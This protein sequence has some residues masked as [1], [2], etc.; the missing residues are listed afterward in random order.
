MVERSRES[1]SGRPPTRSER[2]AATRGRLISAALEIVRERGPGALTTTELTRA[3][4]IAQPSFYV[5]FDNVDDCLSA[6][7]EEA[8]QRIT[9][10]LKTARAEALARVGTADALEGALDATLDVLLS[11][12]ALVDVFLQHRR[13]P[14]S[15]LGARLRDVFERAR[16]DLLSDL[17]A[18]ADA[19]GLPDELRAAIPVTAELLIAQTLAVVEGHIDGRLTDRA[20]SVRVLSHFTATA[21]FGAPAALPGGME[22]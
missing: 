1:R 18:A 2:K 11:E 8:G 19:L 12:P 5:H 17:R 20:L 13:D 22:S 9:D 4:G 16:A 7:A 14:S 21:L 6:A 3:A 10:L 15:A